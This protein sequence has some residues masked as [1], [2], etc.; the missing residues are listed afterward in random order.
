MPKP[1]VIGSADLAVPAD[2]TA[3]ANT[4]AASR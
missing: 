3:A 1:I 2:S 4:A